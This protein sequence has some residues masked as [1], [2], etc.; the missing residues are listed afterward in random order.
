MNQYKVLDYLYFKMQRK[1][2]ICDYFP[3]YTQQ[4]LFVRSPI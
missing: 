4:S 2:D 1:L 3:I